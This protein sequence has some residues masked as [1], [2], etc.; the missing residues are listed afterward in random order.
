MTTEEKLVELAWKMGETS[1]QSAAMLASH[2]K[3]PNANTAEWLAEACSDMR[4]LNARRRRLEN[5]R[6]AEWNQ[7]A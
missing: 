2:R 4:K 1:Q 5:K 7:A 3:A 6:F